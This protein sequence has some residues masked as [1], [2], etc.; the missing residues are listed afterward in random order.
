MRAVHEP[1][2]AVYQAFNAR[3]I[4]AAL[5]A[6]HPQVDWPNGMEGGRL[7]GRDRVRAYWARQWSLIDP[8]VVPLRFEQDGA[9]RIMVDV[10][11]IVRDLAGNTLSDRI[12]QHV[13]TIRDGL[14]EHM[15]IRDMNPPRQSP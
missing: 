5:A 4:D 3:D 1:L 2:S 13:Y 15:E 6:L 9:G 11:Q 10:H 12:V 14:V 7:R 8:R